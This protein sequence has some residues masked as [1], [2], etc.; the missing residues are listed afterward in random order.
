MQELQ[1]QTMAGALQQLQQWAAQSAGR[2][3]QQ[4]ADRPSSSSHQQ[5]HQLQPDTSDLLP[6]VALSLAS[7]T[8]T[9]QAYANLLCTLKQQ[10]RAVGCSNESGLRGC[11]ISLQQVQGTAAPCHPPALAWHACAVGT[12]S[13]GTRAASAQHAHPHCTHRC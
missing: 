6:T 12:A 3:W 2:V 5:N 8:N 9:A 4:Q 1:H 13:S 11:W 10:V 7:S